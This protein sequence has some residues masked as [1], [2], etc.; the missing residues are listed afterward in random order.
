M[1]QVYQK[2]RIFF[3]PRSARC[4]CCL[5]CYHCGRAIVVTRHALSSTSTYRSTFCISCHCHMDTGHCVLLWTAHES[6]GE[7]RM[8]RPP[9]EPQPQRRLPIGIGKPLSV[10][11]LGGPLL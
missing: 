11:P 9:Q 2:E 10:A 7:E 6:A 3:N 4:S 1:P 8:P 5:D